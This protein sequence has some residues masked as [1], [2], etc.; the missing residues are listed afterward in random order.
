MPKSGRGRLHYSPSRKKSRSS[1]FNLSSPL[2]S[3]LLRD[4]SLCKSAEEESDDG[5][6][7]NGPFYHPLSSE[8]ERGDSAGYRFTW[9]ASQMTAA[10]HAAAVEFR[11]ETNRIPDDGATPDYREGLP[12][13]RYVLF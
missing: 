10:A 12:K 5:H 3:K 4:K 2:L 9:D 1:P 11:L 8:R 7:K 13:C 6:E